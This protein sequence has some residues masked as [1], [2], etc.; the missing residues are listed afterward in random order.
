MRAYNRKRK[1][2]HMTKLKYVLQ[3]TE[4][5]YLLKVTQLTTKR[6]SVSEFWKSYR[7]G[8]PHTKFKTYK[9]KD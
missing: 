7:N 8:K 9:Y 6:K 5:T 1:H 4:T 3:E 2:K